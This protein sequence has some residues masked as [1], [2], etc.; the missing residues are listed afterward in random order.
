MASRLIDT[1]RP[2]SR[3]RRADADDRFGRPGLVPGLFFE[4]PFHMNS[5]SFFKS[6]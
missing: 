6:L 4:Q 3:A 1:P 5:R 2:P